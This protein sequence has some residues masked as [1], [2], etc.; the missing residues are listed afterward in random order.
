MSQDNPSQQGM[1]EPEVLAK[2]FIPGGVHSAV[3]SFEKIGGQPRYWQCGRGAYLIDHQQRM[4]LDYIG[5]FGPL[6]LGHSHPH[7][8][9][10]M[11]DQAALA[12]VHGGCH[13]NE[14]R[15]AQLITQLMPS[16]QKVRMMNSGT[17]AVIAAIRLAQHYTGRQSIL[18]FQGSYHG[19]ADVTLNQHTIHDPVNTIHGATYLARYNDIDDV[20]QILSSV[21]NQLAAIIVEPVAGNMGCIPP[22]PEF[23]SGLQTLCKQYGIVYILDEVMTGFRVAL[24]GAQAHYQVEPDL[25]VLGKIIGGGL[26]AGA[27][28][29]RADIMNLASPNGPARMGGTFSSNPM[30]V[31]SGLAMLQYLSAHADELY[32]QLSDYTTHLTQELKAQAKHY[33]VPLTTHSVGGMMGLFFSEG[34]VDHYDHVEQCSQEHFRDFFHRMLA[35][36]ILIAADSDEAQFISSEHGED[37]LN[38]TLNASKEVFSSMS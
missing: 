35:Q 28:G 20:A 27:V 29:G 19:T 18:K 12:T 21:G 38:L 32:P 10:A 16:I 37:E 6:I 5:G 13:L 14:I 33:G 26:P 9:K 24:G 22:K 2:Q 30:T 36:G 4:Y 23:L 34:P 8:V 17:E 25:T 11:Q 3:R 15:F 31:A 7:M 1:A